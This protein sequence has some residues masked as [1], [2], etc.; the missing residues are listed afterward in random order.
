MGPTARAEWESIQR[1]TNPELYFEEV[2]AFGARQELEQ[3]LEIAAEVYSRL[4]R[5]AGDYPAILRRARERLDAVQGRGNW[6]PRAEFLLRRLAQEASEPTA[7]FAMG[8]AGAAFRVTRLAALSRLSAAPGVNFLTRGFGARAISGLAGFTVEAPTF[9]LA[10]RLAGTALGR[11]QD[12]GLRVL[13]RDLASSF[14]VLGGLKLAGWG[15]G[16]VHRGLAGAAGTLRERPLQILFQQGGMLTGILLGHRM[17]E[18]AGLRLPVAGATTLVDS[19]AMLLQFNVAG[20]LT[21]HAFGPRFHAWETGLDL[22]SELLARGRPPRGPGWWENLLPRPALA[23]ASGVAS[24]PV[25]GSGNP[26]QGPPIVAMS[27]F[28]GKP[29]EFL[30]GGP[31]SHETLTSEFRREYP[32]EFESLLA[33][34]EGNTRDPSYFEGTREELLRRRPN[35]EA[36]D[37][38]FFHQAMDLFRR[39]PYVQ[40][41]ELTAR[42][43]SEPL[44]EGASDAGLL[45]RAME[46]LGPRAFEGSQALRVLEVRFPRGLPAEAMGDPNRRSESN[47]SLLSP[48]LEAQAKLRDRIHLIQMGET[49]V[50][51]RV[52]SLSLFEA[53]LQSAFGRDAVQFH[54]VDGTIPRDQ[55]MALRARRVSPVGLSRHMLVLGDVS[56][57]V[58]PFAF[59]THDAFFHGSIDAASG[60]GQLARNG[61]L[62]GWVRERGDRVEEAEGILNSLSDGELTQAT[63]F[64]GA[65][66][67]RRLR[68]AFRQELELLLR[69]PDPFRR[70]RG[71]FEL[72]R[73]VEEMAR[74]AEVPLSRV[75][76]LE[77][78]DQEAWREF[79][80]FRRRLRYFFESSTIHYSPE[81]RPIVAAVERSKVQ[82]G[83]LE[84]SREE[85]LGKRVDIRLADRLWFY[86]ALD[87]AGRIP[88]F[89][90]RELDAAALLETMPFRETEPDR[91]LIEAALR[92]LDREAPEGSI[93]RRVLEFSFPSSR[94]SLVDLHAQQPH[95]RYLAEIPFVRFLEESLDERVCLMGGNIDGVTIRI[96]SLSLTEALIQGVHGRDRAQFHFVDGVISRDDNMR[97]KALRV[98]PVGLTLSRHYFGEFDGDIHPFSFAQHDAFEHAARDASVARGLPE[99]AANVYFRARDV[100]SESPQR[101]SFLNDLSDL[102]GMN[103]S[104]ART[105]LALR[106]LKPVREAFA[107]ARQQRDPERARALLQEA[108]DFAEAGLRLTDID[109]N[110]LSNPESLVRRPLLSLRVRLREAMSRV[111]E[112]PSE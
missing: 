23:L 81:M 69:H 49:E 67:G 87:F 56:D 70:A 58:F 89:Q 99:A 95:L 33:E 83:Y 38:L 86:Q 60:P 66:L 21:R 98:N 37:R 11:E 17:E 44:F 9:T 82:P 90:V 106:I 100:F 24:R 25:A 28:G 73:N 75:K 103:G 72:H 96:P 101:E 22:H 102:N 97:L 107:R 45:Q 14:L 6:A 16:A 40:V 77:R 8:A 30:F 92:S 42:D 34:V 35:G 84:G 15:A 88:E 7:L 31:P 74:A 94:L 55:V 4:L 10:G 19:L 52:I 36:V 79:Q 65:T 46:I 111:A 41:R 64:Y 1:G 68:G 80:F 18:W 3:R 53:L 2:L 54:Y 47:L 48:M 61:Q 57:W 43:L 109:G 5:E 62:Y 39:V 93:H 51:V 76:R 12:W 13:G 85:L 20:R 104:D 91:P 78:A 110:F 108:L 71:L 59:A 112:R 50:Q 29:G 27:I 32:P 63:E 26:L 105:V